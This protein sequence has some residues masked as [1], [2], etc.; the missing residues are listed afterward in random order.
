M[1]GLGRLGEPK[2]L[3]LVAGIPGSVLVEAH[4]A[5]A[6]PPLK[7]TP[8]RRL[9]LHRGERDEV[10]PEVAELHLLVDHRGENLPDLAILDELDVWTPALLNREEFLDDSERGPVTHPLV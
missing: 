6:M 2:Q 5:A 10:D 4:S 8:P 1:R 9:V 7:H 3:V